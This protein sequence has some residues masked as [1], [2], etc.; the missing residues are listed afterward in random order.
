[1]VSSEVSFLLLPM[2]G[3]LRW[4][5]AILLVIRYRLLVIRYRL[6]ETLLPYNL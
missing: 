3:G 4:C 5:Q 1:M 2:G 6:Y